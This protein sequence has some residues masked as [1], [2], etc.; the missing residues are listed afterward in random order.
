MVN[1]ALLGRTGPHQD[2]LQGNHDGNH[3]D[4]SSESESRWL[5]LPLN[6]PNLKTAF[7]NDVTGK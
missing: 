1:D 5:Q 7:T 6:L 4:V 2:E 3:P